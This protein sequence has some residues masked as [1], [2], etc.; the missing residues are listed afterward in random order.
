MILNKKETPE[1]G[2]PR[3]FWLEVGEISLDGILEKHGI[4]P[5][6]LHRNLAT[7]RLKANAGKWVNQI[8]AELAQ[9]FRNN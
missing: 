8:V 7:D 9:N 4:V 3:L 1:R 2:D 5:C 6:H